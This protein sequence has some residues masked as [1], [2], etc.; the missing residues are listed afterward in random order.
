MRDF[1]NCL[2]TLPGVFLLLP[3]ERLRTDGEEENQV[4]GT[5]GV[6]MV[7]GERTLRCVI[8]IVRGLLVPVIAAA[9]VVKLKRGML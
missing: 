2:Q 6:G 5:A 1:T 9:L 8:R 3:L 7:L 4:K